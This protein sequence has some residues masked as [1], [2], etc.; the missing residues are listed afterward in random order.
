MTTAKMNVL[1]IDDEEESLA[2]LNTAVEYAFPGTGFTTATNGLKGIDLALAGNP[3]II[4]LDIIMPEMDGFEVC[5]RLKEDVRLR[6]IPVVFLTALKPNREICEKA[7]EAGGE[8]FILKPLELW[9]LTV[10]LRAMLKIKAANIL[11]RTDQD[12]LGILVAQR[13]RELAEEL[14]VREKAL[15]SLTESEALFKTIFTESPMG[16][17][18]VDAKTGRFLS[19]NPMFT[20]I[21][22]RS[23]E[24]LA[25]IDWH[26]ITHSDDIKNQ[27]DNLALLNAGKIK[28]FQVEKRYL[29]PGGTVVWTSLTAAPLPAFDNANPRYLGMIEDIS[30]AKAAGQERTKLEEQ[31]RQSQ[32]META[33]RLAGGIAHDFNNILAAI[34]AYSEFLLK[35]LAPDDPRHQDAEEINKAGLRAAALTRQLLAFS[36]KQVLQPK[37][38]DVNP[39]I[40]DIKTMLKQLIGGNIKLTAVTSAAPALIKADQGYLEQVLLNLCINARDAMPKGGKITIE[41]SVVHMEK[42]YLHH[43]GTLE[44][45]DYVMLSVSDTGCGMSAEIQSH[46]FEPFFTTK[47]R[48]QGTGL[49]LSTVHGII[50]Q[51]GGSIVVHSEEGHGTVFK[52]YFPQATGEAAIIEQPAV[53]KKL[54]A[55]SRTVLVVEDD[56]QM[57]TLV[58]R[59]LAQDGHVVLEAA[60]AEEALAVCKRHKGPVHLV[61][62]D[63]VLP[64]KN[65]L[66][67]AADLEALHHGIKLIFMSGYTCRAIRIMPPWRKAYWIR[68]K[69]L[70]RNLSHW[71]RLS[72]RCARRCSRGPPP[73]PQKTPEGPVKAR[74]GRITRPR[75]IPLLVS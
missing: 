18:L 33:G 56:L 60:S 6:H 64:K 42:A 24:E 23:L 74:R 38:L 72:A 44:P 45:G 25:A 68:T 16:I 69:V 58:R 11:Q 52:I 12:K 30:A 26:S 59:T 54:A 9:E 14:A 32:K 73:R 47:P 28:V 66:E 34:L 1:A 67:L 21:V 4:L 46:L 19:A 2:V 17:C 57:R 41:A 49:G 50:K 15:E 7:F 65:G 39:V 36:R 63:M 10:Q 37:V 61:L 70:S 62:T 27:S 53:L 31:L 13:T 55:G 5:R 35:S 40:L 20:R 75:Q 71:T 48:D 22:G 8:A 29:K 51:S 43:N 3:D